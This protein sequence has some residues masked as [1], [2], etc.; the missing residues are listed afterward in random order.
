MPGDSP[1]DI[2]PGDPPDTPP[3][4]P[5]PT[6]WYEYEDE[7]DPLY[8]SPAPDEAYVDEM[9]ACAPDETA[10]AL[11][12]ALEFQQEVQRT[13]AGAEPWEL[14]EEQSPP[15]WERGSRDD[16]EFDDEGYWIPEPRPKPE[17]EPD[18]GPEPRYE[19]WLV[20][21]PD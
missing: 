17:P 16:L 18:Q 5:L 8:T 21:D 2:S 4:T 13:P 15:V 9:A 19:D 11:D 12:A 7:V 6:E 3:Y 14:P 20:E 10:A 1:P